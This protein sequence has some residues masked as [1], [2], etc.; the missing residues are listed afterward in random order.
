[1]AWVIKDS[2]VRLLV[3]P[4]RIAYHFRRRH[5][6]KVRAISQLFSSSCRTL[7]MF[8]SACELQLLCRL[9]I[10]RPSAGTFLRYTSSVPIRSLRLLWSARNW[11]VRISWDVLHNC[12]N[13]PFRLNSSQ[14]PDKFDHKYKPNRDELFL[15]SVTRVLCSARSQLKEPVFVEKIWWTPFCD[16]YSWQEGIFCRLLPAVSCIHRRL[17]CT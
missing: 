14:M 10:L 7:T 6:Y 4:G 15:L 5:L 16:P 2:F 8:F 11:D 12:I 17:D 3:H 1:M 13:D 9:N